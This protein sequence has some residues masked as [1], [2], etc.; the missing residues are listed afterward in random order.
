MI[1][2]WFEYDRNDPSFKY[3]QKTDIWALGVIFCQ[4]I[5]GLH[6]FSNSQVYQDFV[7]KEL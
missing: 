4:I 7:K 2:Q 3:T 5:T 1:E 6:P